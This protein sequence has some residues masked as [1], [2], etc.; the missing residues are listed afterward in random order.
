MFFLS[1]ASGEAKRCNQP[2]FLT[3]ALETVVRKWKFHLTHHA[4]DVRAGGRFANITLMIL[5]YV[6]F[7]PCEIVRDI[8]QT[9][10]RPMVER[11]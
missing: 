9:I 7:T 11:V 8:L 4:L 10:G 2:R 3:A 6:L 1:L 5:W